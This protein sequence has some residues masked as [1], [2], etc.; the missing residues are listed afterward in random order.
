MTK[1]LT[2]FNK[3]VTDE[4]SFRPALTQTVTELG[5]TSAHTSHT[6]FYRHFLKRLL[7]VL[8]VL[9]SVPLVV[10]LIGFLALMVALDGGKPFFSQLRVGR[11]GR[12]FRIWKLRSMV[13]DSDKRLKTYLAENPEARR[14]WNQMQKLQDDPRITWVGR[15]LR[16]S[17]L[18][19]LPQLLNVLGGSM[20]L[21][22]PRPMLPEQRL[23]YGGTAYF[24]LRPGIT[25]P[26]Q[27]SDR[28][29]CSFAKRVHYDEGYDRDLSF[30]TDLRILTKTVFVVLRGTGC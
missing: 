11:G 20:A 1:H 7:E 5:W 9:I 2:D 29:T 23:R 10:P 26:W 15:I 14:E 18:D 22:G 17:S 27:I 24:R 16:K 25:G 12:T 19:E 30:W 21:V 8:L 3:F 4:A 6:Q 28:N 13:H